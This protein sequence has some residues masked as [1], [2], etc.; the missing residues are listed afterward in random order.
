M[1]S[2][3][4]HFSTLV[5]LALLCFASSIPPLAYAGASDDFVIAV[6]T[7]NPGSSCT[8]FT[9]PTSGSG[10]NYN[11][12]F[13]NDGTLEATAQTGDY[14]SECSV[15]ACK[16]FRGVYQSPTIHIPSVRQSRVR[17]LGQVKKVI[18]FQMRD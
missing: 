1:L 7:D 17:R 11:V 6:K 15:S 14:T 8:R 4:L 16:R 9:I 5:P 3:R 10:Y 2:R 13:N 18:S 12:D